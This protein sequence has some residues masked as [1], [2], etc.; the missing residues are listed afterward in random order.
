MQIILNDPGWN[1]AVTWGCMKAIHR[2]REST[3][4]GID[5]SVLAQFR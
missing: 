4:G 5:L 2:A 1:R 3:I